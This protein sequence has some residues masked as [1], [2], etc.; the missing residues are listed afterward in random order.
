MKWLKRSALALALLLLTAAVLPFLIPL[1][2]YIPRLEKEA[3]ARLHE[4]VSIERIRLSALPLPHVVVDGIAIGASGD[5]K[6]KRVLLSPDLLSLL[7]SDKVIKRIEIDTPVLTQEAIGRIPAWARPDP[8][9]PPQAAPQI[10]IE[11]IRFTSALVDFGKGKFGPFDARVGLDAKGALENVSVATQDGKLEASIKPDKAGYLIDV[12]A[13]SWTLPLGPPLVFD[14]LAVK[15]AASAGGAKLGAVNA[16]LYGGTAAGSMTID[17]RKGLQLEGRLDVRRMELKQV[18]ALLSP[19]ARLSGK[20]SAKPVFSASA[21]TADRLLPALRLQTHFDIRDGVL[22]GVDIKEAAT[23]LVKRGTT[24][25]ETRFEQLSGDLRLER[26]AYRFTRLS[27]ASGALAANGRVNISAKKALSGRI[28]AEVKAAGTSAGVPLN[29]GGTIDAPL[30]YPTGGTI[31]G[32]AAGT[33]ILGPGVGTSVGAKVGGW[34]ENLFGK[35][36]EDPPNK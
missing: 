36:D 27:I 9:Q 24:G 10:R 26:G 19:G 34:I 21:A 7:R 13:K 15:A 22:N 8:A 32:A 18:A 12:S 16:K 23:S 2:G 25:G 6:V 28:N 3:T 14:A 4:P 30:L 1:D 31:A 33:A 20:L 17:W 11:D 35:E 29:V 5:V